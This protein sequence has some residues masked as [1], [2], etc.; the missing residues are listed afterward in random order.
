MLRPASIPQTIAAG[1]PHESVATAIMPENAM[2][3]GSERSAM[4]P[5]KVTKAM[6]E[7]TI[8]SKA[9]AFRMVSIF[10]VV[11]KPADT[12]R[13]TTSSKKATP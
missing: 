7:A 5:E 13:P 9:T 6:P 10:S 8:P 3:E 12:I 1:K 2:I 11:R 4:C